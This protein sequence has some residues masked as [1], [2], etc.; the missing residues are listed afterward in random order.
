M[1][2]MPMPIKITDKMKTVQNT[3]LS[4]NVYL[5]SSSEF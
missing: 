4:F 3:G 2:N 5:K 1:P